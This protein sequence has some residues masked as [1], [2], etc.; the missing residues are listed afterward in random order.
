MVKAIIFDLDN[1]LI[2]FVR[3]KKLSC[4]AAIDAMIDNGLDMP[5]K[6]AFDLLFKLYDKLGWEYQ[7]IFQLFLKEATGRIDYKLVAAGV[8][9]YKRVKEGLI[10]PYPGVTATLKRLRSR[11]YKLAILTDAPRIQAWTRLVSMGLQNEFDFVV[12]FDDTKVKKPNKRPF[13]LI[14]K[15]LRIGPDE[16]VMVGDSF[17]RDL[18]PAKNLGMT[19]AF[20]KYGS[21][22]DG[23]ADYI[24]NN[25]S[26]LLKFF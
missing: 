10:Y 1:T 5:K 4:E 6:K 17:I 21:E 23:K 7:K 22:E 18:S 12:T 8:V 13:L 15:K 19:T 11:G 16:A 20:A 24:L 3:M 25:V 14:L 2:D 9:G 26:D